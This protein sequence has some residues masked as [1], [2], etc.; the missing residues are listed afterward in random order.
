MLYVCRES[1]CAISIRRISNLN[2]TESLRVFF[3]TRAADY[4]FN[5]DFFF[6]T[7]IS[8]ILKAEIFFL[9]PIYSVITRGCV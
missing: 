6:L 3:S 9:P 2:G 7:P 5:A 1:V 8:R 4:W